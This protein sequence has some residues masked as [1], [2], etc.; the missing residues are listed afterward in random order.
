M[1]AT[2]PISLPFHLTD[3]RLENHRARWFFAARVNCSDDGNVVIIVPDLLDDRRRR[4]PD[5]AIEAD[6]IDDPVGATA[7]EVN[8][9]SIFAGPTT[10]ISSP[11]PYRPVRAG[12]PGRC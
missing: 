3:E 9:P 4:V 10:L 2:A 7:R 12:F 8:D 11:I 1:N 6:G 5:H